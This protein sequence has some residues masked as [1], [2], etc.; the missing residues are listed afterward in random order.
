MNAVA[1]TFVSE[2]E[3]NLSPVPV[4]PRQ[5]YQLGL[6]INRLTEKMYHLLKANGSGISSR[7][8]K[9][10]IYSRKE[11]ELIKEKCTYFHNCELYY[12]YLSG[13]LMAVNYEEPLDS[14][15]LKSNID[16]LLFKLHRNVEICESYEK[17]GNKLKSSE[18]YKF[19]N[20]IRNDIGNFY[21][22]AAALYPQGAIYQAFI[23]LNKLTVQTNCKM[24]NSLQL[25]RKEDAVKVQVE[26][27]S[28]FVETC[29]HNIKTKGSA[30]LKIV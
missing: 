9:W 25:L 26:G 27:I 1:R 24:F 12:Y 22:S 18:I 2:N 8:D 3:A 15:A 14:S 4:A 29:L 7:N 20:T 11:A 6:D 28:D 10:L 21:K 23:T 19:I 17:D 5:V 16:W 13:G 30:K